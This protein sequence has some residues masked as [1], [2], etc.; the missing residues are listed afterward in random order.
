MTE[1]P[2]PMARRTVEWL[3]TGDRAALDPNVLRRLVRN[4]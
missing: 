1:S 3:G 4:D 2:P